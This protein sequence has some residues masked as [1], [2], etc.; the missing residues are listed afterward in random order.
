MLGVWSEAIH[1]PKRAVNVLNR[2]GIMVS[3]DTTR[4]ALT[5]IAKHDR[6][7]VMAKIEAGRPFGI[8][9]DNLVRMDHKQEETLMNKRSLEQNTSAYIHF[10]HIPAPSPQADEATQSTYQ[11]IQQK[12]QQNKGVCLPRSLLYKVDAVSRPI[13]RALFLADD[14]LAFH[15]K[16][17]ARLR[18]GQTFERILGRKVLAAYKVDGK[19]LEL[20]SLPETDEYAFLPPE[21]TDMHSLHTMEL[22]ETTIDGT[23]MVMEDIMDYC[24]VTQ[25]ELLTRSVFATGDQLSNARARALKDLRVRDDVVERYEWAVTK[26]G[27]LHVSMAYVQGFLKCHMAGKS[28]KDSTSLTRFAAMLARTRL[29]PDGKL[30]DF[31]AANRF[32]T[33]AWEGYVIAAAVTQANVK[34][35]KQLS[36]WVQTNNWRDLIEKI[37]NVYFPAQKVAFQR[38]QAR[39]RALEEYL[40]LRSKVMEIPAED[41]TA[42]QRAFIGAKSRESYVNVTPVVISLELNR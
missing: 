2:C 32:V 41:R 33:A 23:A 6:D 14:P 18:I 38:E 5:A 29:S 4:K 36:E 27:T 10:L 19:Q 34:S 28:G 9:W 42:R 11:N 16:E 17:I 24:G 12:L 35:I 30:V 20:P 26:P 22:D 8:F 13:D 40:K 25:A 39:E 3:Y 37:V 21:R 15:L 1:I 31:N 7:M